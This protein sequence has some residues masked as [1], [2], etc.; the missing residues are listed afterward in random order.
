MTHPDAP[1]GG[2]PADNKVITNWGEPRKFDFP[3]KDHV[4]VAE[5]L[6][7][8]D[9]EAGAAVA[10]QKFYYLKR[11]AVL[12]ELALVQYAFGVLLDT[13]L[14][15]SILVPA[16]ALDLGDR[17]W[18]PSD[19]SRPKSGPLEPAT[20]AAAAGGGADGGGP[21]TPS[22]AAPPFSRDRTPGPRSED[23]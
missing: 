15:R 16:I 3:I 7:L 4:T 13:F 14:V 2:T 10:G 19:L 22:P 8:V 23:R 5:G 1:V 12:L 18:W 9:F 21:R 20:A 11:D 17:F 6:D